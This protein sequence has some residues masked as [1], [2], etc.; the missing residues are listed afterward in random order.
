VASGLAAAAR[1]SADGAW[2]QVAEGGDLAQD[3]GALEF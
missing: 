2:A 1:D 3:L